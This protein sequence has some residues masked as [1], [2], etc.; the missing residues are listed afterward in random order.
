MGVEISGKGRVRNLILLLLAL[1]FPIP[2]EDGMPENTLLR[3]KA[4]DEAV[5]IVETFFALEPLH[6][7]KR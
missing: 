3:E 4:V 6:R 5:P 1:A 2:D 7:R